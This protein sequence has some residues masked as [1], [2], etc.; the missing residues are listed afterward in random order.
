DDH[1]KDHDVNQA[2]EVLRVVHRADAWNDSQHSRYGRIRTARLR[3]KWLLHALPGHETRLTQNLPV[4]GVANTRCA[5]RFPAI[6]AIR[7]CCHSLMIYAVHT[8]LP[9]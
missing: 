2:F 4:A 9:S 8:V 5:E 7:C 3:H 1:H 6:L